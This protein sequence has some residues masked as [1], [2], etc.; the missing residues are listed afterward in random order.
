MTAE[1]F[2]EWASSCA[3]ELATLERRAET[4]RLKGSSGMTA[5]RGAS[6]GDPTASQ[7][8]SAMTDEPAI[9]EGIDRCRRVLRRELEVTAQVG[10]V[11]G[12]TAALA[13][14]LH[15]REGNDWEAVA[16]E[17]GFSLRSIYRL[18]RRAFEWVDAEGLVATLGRG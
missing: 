6:F 7:A 13:L 17:L 5:S 2:Y 1:E 14:R 4:L 15:Y 10:A 16:F 18:R 9:L 8:M 3:R 11:M 12:P